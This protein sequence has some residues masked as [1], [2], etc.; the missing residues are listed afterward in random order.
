MFVFDG[1]EQILR[2]D[3]RPKPA[4]HEAFNFFDHF[5]WP[6]ASYWMRRFSK[7]ATKNGHASNEVFKR[8]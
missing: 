1:L 2:C 7:T 6:C 3:D 8:F 4:Q 5:N